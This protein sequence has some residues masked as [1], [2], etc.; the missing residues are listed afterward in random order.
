MKAVVKQIKLLRR[1]VPGKTWGKPRE[2][3]VRILCV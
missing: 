2:I 3:S 1:D